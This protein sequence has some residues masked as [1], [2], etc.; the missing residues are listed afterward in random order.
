MRFLI[1]EDMDI[2]K[3]KL[4]TEQAIPDI[5]SLLKLPG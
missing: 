4:L 5:F 2:H 3:S 1:T